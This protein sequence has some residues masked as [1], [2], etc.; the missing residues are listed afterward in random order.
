V[1]ANPAEA[2][3]KARSAQRKYIKH[4]RPE[5]MVD[6][7]A[8]FHEKTLVS[9]GYRP[10]NG[11]ATPSV[12]YILR[13][14][15]N[16]VYIERTLDSLAAQSYDNLTVLLVLYKPLENLEHLLGKYGNRLRFKVVEDFGSLRGR[17]IARA[18]R[19]IDTEYFG[20]I[21]DDDTLHRNHV[22]SLIRTFEYHNNR[23]F[24]GE[25][26]VAYAGSYYCSDFNTFKED[27]Q[28]VDEYLDSRP[29]HRVL[30]HFRFYSSS[31][32]ARHHWY[33]MSNS[34][35]ASKNI[36]DDESF[37]DPKSNTGED[38]FFELQF[39]TRSYFAFSCEMTAV[40]WFHNTNSTVIDS[41]R[42]EFD[43][44]RH[45]L[46]FFGRSFPMMTAYS[47]A[48]SPKFYTADGDI[49]AM[50]TPY[51][52]ITDNYYIDARVYGFK[53][54]MQRFLSVWRNQGLRMAIK[55]ALV[56]MYSRL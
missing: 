7:F 30:E 41:H 33:M 14:G 29:R 53:S 40:H 22:R 45:A 25:I 19:E 27:P 31:M 4:F 47:P 56:Y 6:R 11:E 13:T 17:A 21:D 49:V 48:Y 34:W 3:Q 55:Q 1:R 36:L 24:R 23:D 35:L 18:M 16:P 32:M 39:A 37:K 46:H 5:A 43:Y 54:K 28:W 52:A 38:L 51:T 12:S 42:H 9:Q 50:E 44:F 8:E 2:A 10:M 15:G 26:K 20:I